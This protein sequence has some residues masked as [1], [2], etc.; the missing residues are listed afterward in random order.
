LPIAKVSTQ[1]MA[2]IL[3]GDTSGLAQPGRGWASTTRNGRAT[4]LLRSGSCS[5][6]YGRARFVLEALKAWAPPRMFEEGGRALVAL[7]VLPDV[8][9]ERV[10]E[11]LLDQLRRLHAALQ[12]ATAVTLT[13]S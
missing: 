8:T 1:H 10:L 13:A 6:E 9:R 5:T 2:G 12:S 3:R 4:A 11:D 7:T